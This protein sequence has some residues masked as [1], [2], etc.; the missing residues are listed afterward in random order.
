[1]K[2]KVTRRTFVATGTAAV[3]AVSLPGRL[4]AQAPT[5]I[6]RSPAKPIVV[7]S[8]NGNRFKNGGEMT[9]AEK[10]YS[11][12]TQGGDVLD[13]LIAGGYILQRDP[14]QDSVGPAGLA[15]T[16]GGAPTAP[17]G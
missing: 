15:E 1:M 11:L 14:P 17:H 5:V 16:R 8:A 10:G 3:A 6:R 4:I 2:N 7:S 12:I 9:R 13:A